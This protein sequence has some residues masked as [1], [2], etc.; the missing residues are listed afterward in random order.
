MRIL[1]TGASSG[2]GRALAEHYARRGDS[3][4]ALARRADVL[5]D[6]ARQFPSLT[7]LPAD[8]TD[9]DAMSR[10][11]HDFASKVGGLDL[12]YANAGIGQQSPDEAWDLA[13]ARTLTSINILGTL[14]TITPALTLM[15]AQRAGHI[16]G[17]SSLAGVTPMPAS[18][19]YGSS[20]AWLAFYLR[21]LEMDLAQSHHLRFTLVL[22]GH[23]STAMVDGSSVGLVTDSARRAAERIASG[24]AAGK[25]T[26]AFPR[27]V[28]LLARLSAFIPHTTR[29]RMQNRRLARRKSQ[30]TSKGLGHT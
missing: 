3:V 23:V 12:L 27:K 28:A 24:V 2:I 7:P 11:V 5:A 29:A 16:V 8:I 10:A 21:S 20:K 13:K 18:A 19:V 15:M 1:I 6:L 9:P 17:I 25:R 30:R 26:I 22:P 14:N 4:G